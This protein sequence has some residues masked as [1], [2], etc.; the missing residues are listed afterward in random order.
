MSANWKKMTVCVYKIKII[1]ITP[2]WQVLLLLLIIIEAE[3]VIM[4]ILLPKNKTNKWKTSRK[5]GNLPGRLTEEKLDEEE[6]KYK[7]KY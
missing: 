5:G 3:I 7:Q 6:K 4:M 1:L 2:Q